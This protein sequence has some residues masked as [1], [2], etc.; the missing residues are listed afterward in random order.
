MLELLFIRIFSVMV[1]ANLAFLAIT[2]A[3]YGLALG[4]LIVYF[5]PKRYSLEHFPTLL[6]KTTL[7]YACSVLAILVILLFLHPEKIDTRAI[8]TAFGLFLIALFPFTFANI[9]LTQIFTY[10]ARQI[11]QL[12]FADLLGGACGVVSAII[13]ISFLPAL[14]VML[15]A[16]LAGLGAVLLFSRWRTKIAIASAGMFLILMGLFFV[17]QLTHILNLGALTQN[18]TSDGNSM[19]FTKWNSFSHVSVEQE[20]NPNTYGIKID[21]GA[22]TPIN[23]FNGNLADY[24][25]LK[26]QISALAF[27]LA[28]RGKVLVI[29]P[30]GGRD[31]L[32]GLLYGHHV[33]GAEINPIIVNDIMRGKFRDFAGSLYNRPDVNIHI[34]EGRSFVKRDTELYQVISIPLVDTWASTAG[35]NL[36]L[37]ENNLYTVEALSDYF[38]RLDNNGILSITRWEKEGP[39]LVSNF[40]VFAK[41][42]GVADPGQHLIVV[43]NPQADR[44]G[45]N[46]Y[47]FKRSPFTQGEISQ[48]HDFAKENALTVLYAPDGAPYT[49]L[50][51]QILLTDGEASRTTERV[52]TAVYDDKPF[53]FFTTP[54]LHSLTAS[55]SNVDGG[56]GVIFLLVIFFTLTVLLFPLLSS[57]QRPWTQAQ[58]RSG[59]ASLLYFAFLGLG[60][61][62]IELALVQ[63]FVL[64][65]EQPIYSYSVVLAAILFSA[66]VG[67]MLGKHW[68]VITPQRGARV[69]IIVILIVAAYAFFLSPML[70]DMLT[71]SLWQKI[72]LAATLSAL[73]TFFMG[74]FLPLGIHLLEARGM[75]HLIPWSWAANG[76]TS[77]LGTVLALIIAIA[78][79]FSTV[80]LVGGAAYVVALLML[81]MAA[82]PKTGSSGNS[83]AG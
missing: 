8:P 52:L 2:V 4:G 9:S 16:V 29:G 57:T 34:S 66:G 62:L 68:G 81:F 73:P 21:A 31:V 19:L 35:G 51:A 22:Y 13:A 49:S 24:S 27:Q 70:A 26:N 61:I 12:Y 59:I 56:L 76:A 41:Q 33:V 39:R 71:L 32:M 38:N 40:L 28:D 46:N 48:V 17:D 67:S 79:G 15:L 47:L 30:G 80:L 25:I 3:L 43:E 64:F 45:L 14:S 10:R 83:G 6:P 77:V 58:K 36:A 37:V 60:F 69:G 53:F 74:M 20:P 5:N 54:L 82:S 75:H 72:F 7:W 23:A 1:V 63:K 42:N 78:G 65:L 11:N 44:L 18:T 50:D 55:I